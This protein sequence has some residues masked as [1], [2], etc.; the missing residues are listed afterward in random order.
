MEEGLM[1]ADRIRKF[2]QLKEVDIR[3]YS[4]LTLA[5]MGD[6]V[7]DLVVRT[8]IVERGNTSVNKLHH[9]TIGYVKAKAQAMLADEL[10]PYLTQEEQEVLRRG[11]NAKPYTKAR[12]ATMSEYKKATS[13]E[14]LIGYL[15]LTGQDD[16]MFF[17]MKLG[18][19]MIDARR[20]TYGK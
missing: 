9:Y 17:L 3:T 8:V 16:R 4:P 18:M 2:F 12:N 14:A 15:Y 7:Y 11:R 19:E 1:F 20:D 13:M 10:L 5:Y 6:A